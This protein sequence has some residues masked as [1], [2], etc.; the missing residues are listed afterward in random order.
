MR[1]IFECSFDPDFLAFADVG[2]SEE[3]CGD[4]VFFARYAMDA[5]C[6]FAKLC[7]GDI[8]KTHTVFVRDPGNRSLQKT[9][10]V[11]TALRI[12]V[13]HAEEM[14]GTR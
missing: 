10:R 14:D 13:M 3:T 1:K 2:I 6:K 8:P 12:V 5:A 4:A 11:V 7:G 9:F